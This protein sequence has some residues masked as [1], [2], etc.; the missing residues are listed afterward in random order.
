MTSD[1]KRKI[2][3]LTNGYKSTF[4]VEGGCSHYDRTDAQNVRRWIEDNSHGRIRG[5]DLV[6]D[7]AVLCTLEERM[8]NINP[9]CPFK[10][11]EFMYDMQLEVSV[12]PR[13]KPIPNGLL[14]AIQADN[15]S[16]VK[17]E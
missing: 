4:R 14:K 1:I 13:G 17:E 11:G 7:G 15:Y 12:S 5:G 3:Y 8:V 2:T 10:G 9:P 16:Q 6:F